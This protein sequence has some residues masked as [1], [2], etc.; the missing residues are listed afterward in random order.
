MTAKPSRSV[1]LYFILVLLAACAEAGPAPSAEPSAVVTTEPGE[2]TSPTP[3]P[4]PIDAQETEVAWRLLASV[5]GTLPDRAMARAVTEPD[6]L[7]EAWSAHGFPGDVP[8]I[9]FANRFVFLLAQPDDACLDELVELDVVDGA[10]QADW[11]P[12]PGGCAEPL[13]YRLHA[14]DVH[15]GHVPPEFTVTAEEPFAQDLEQVTISLPPYDGEAPAAPEPPEQMAESELDRVFAATDVP[16]CAPRDTRLGEPQIDGPLSDDPEVAE[17]QRQRADEGFP[18]DV[19]ST[20][21][22]LNSSAAGPLYEAPVTTA[23]IAA[24]RARSELADQA[25]TVLQEAGLDPARDFTTL[26][27]RYGRYSEE[28]GVHVFVGEDDVTRVQQILD[29]E[30]GEGAVTAEYSGFDPAQQRKVQERLAPMFEGGREGPGAVTSTSGSI[31]P[32]VIGM[33]DPTREALDRV[34]ELVD[35]SRVCVEPQLSGVTTPDQDG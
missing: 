7:A 17:A 3:T 10:L 28:R 20:R 21:E 25:T 16:R 35:P 32:V 14:I 22:A 15:R 18:S 4:V 26:I 24:E 1:L 6:A 12:P 29:R 9:D 31:G 19:A 34:A 33:V 5:E 30:L 8:E 13:I 2:E 27:D 23:E 11:L